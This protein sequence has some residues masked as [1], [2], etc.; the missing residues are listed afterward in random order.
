MKKVWRVQDVRGY[1]PCHDSIVDFERRQVALEGYY[2]GRQPTPAQDFPP[3]TWS[4]GMLFGFPSVEAAVRWFGERPL[5]RLDQMGYH[6]QR[7]PAAEVYLSLS[8]R[9]VMFV[10]VQDHFNHDHHPLTPGSSWSRVSA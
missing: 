5:Q 8:H 6:L 4:M 1:G 2:D 3:G 9:Q 10:P 7:V